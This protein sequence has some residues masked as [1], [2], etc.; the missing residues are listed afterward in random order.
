MAAEEN[1]DLVTVSNALEPRDEKLLFYTL[2]KNPIRRQIITLLKENGAMAATELKRFLG[3]S[4]G[5]LYYHLEFMHPFVVKTSKRKYMLSDKGLRLVESMKVSDFLA[6]SSV[7]GFQGPRR[8]LLM[9]TLNPLL[10]RV[11]MSRMTMVPVAFL[12]SILYVVLSWRLSNSQ[13]LLHFRQMPTS[14]AALVVSA[15]NIFVLM[16]LL[17]ISGFIATLR[18]GGESSIALTLPIALT[19]S[20]IL[21]T[22]FALTSGFGITGDSLFNSATSWVYLVLHVWQMAA[23]SAVLV[24]AK[25]VSWERAVIASAALSYISLF[26]SSNL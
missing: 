7:G 23:V 3:I 12:T 13:V 16:G 17:M 19:P 1:P 14:E 5:T 20:I 25:G 24:S 8:Y 26:V 15:L 22:Y 9:L 21:L 6:E 4:V 2:L 18:L 11:Q 10:D